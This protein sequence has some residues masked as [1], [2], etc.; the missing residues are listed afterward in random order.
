MNV[1]YVASHR[2][3]EKLSRVL[4][5][6]SLIALDVEAAGF[7]RYSDR[8]C[9]VQITASGKTFLVDPLAFDPS[10]ALRPSLEDPDVRVVIHG[11]DYDLRLLDRDL[12]INPLGLFDTQS[13]A[14]LLG[15]EGLGLS[16]LLEKYLGVR[17]SKKHQRADWAQRP[18]PKR[19]LKYAADDT[20][21]LRR[22][23]EFLQRRLTETGRL[24]WAEEEF[25]AMERIRWVRRREEDPLTRIREARHLTPLEATRLRTGLTWRDAIAREL[26]RAPFRVIGESALLRIARERPSTV[27][28]LARLPGVSERLAGTHGAQLLDGLEEIDRVSDSELLPY[29]NPQR[30]APRPPPEV[31]LRLRRLKSVRNRR[32]D[33][34]G[35]AR[36]TLLANAMLEKI[37]LLWPAGRHDL[38]AIDGMKRW[39]VEATGEILLTA[40]GA[41]SEA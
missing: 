20:R 24:P 15:E 32:A 14:A 40:L 16:A 22:L 18:I 2:A 6:E 7:H 19:L 5:S 35:I 8:L 34:L 17:L 11:P 39:Q 37:A 29:P 21:H 27:E 41:R 9:L 38:R 10:D 26:D 23:A 12:G 33:E 3:G 13:A 31:E 28:E 1:S 4:E 30:S 36:G 25:R